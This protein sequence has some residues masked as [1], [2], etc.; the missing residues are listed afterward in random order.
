VTNLLRFVSLLLP[1]PLRRGFLEKQFGYQIHP[2][3]SIGFAWVFPSRLIMEQ[4]TRIDHLTVCK[5]IDLLHLKAHS[6][7]GRGNWITGFPLGPSRHFAHQGDRRPELVIEEHSAITHRH[8][9][10]CTNSVRIGKFTTVAGFQSQIITH[11]IDIHENRQTSAPIQIGDYCFVGTNCVLI[12][13]SA[14]PSF[15]V[16]GAKS[17]LNKSF[18]ETHQ[19]YGG[20]PARAIQ[21]LPAESKYFQRTE[22]FVA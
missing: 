15:C 19:L 4:E 3:A 5:N 17:L 10:D 9:I 7:I 2:T 6:V 21:P 18:T 13:G 22:G 12:G 1:W 16:L 8:L 11:W 14:L 20:A